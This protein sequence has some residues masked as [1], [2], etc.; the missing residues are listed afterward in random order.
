[1]EPQAEGYCKESTVE[2]RSLLEAGGALVGC[3]R[4]A[5]KG[6]L[7]GSQVCGSQQKASL[8]HLYKGRLKGVVLG[9][10]F[11]TLG[12]SESAEQARQIEGS[13]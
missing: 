10:R 6:A 2:I 1:M 4:R 13:Q 5:T 8:T 11:R 7:S 3:R 12:I 9:M